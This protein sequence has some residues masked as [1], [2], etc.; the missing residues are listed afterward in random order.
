MGFYVYDRMG[1]QDRHGDDADIDSVIAEL[2]E[3]LHEDPDDQE[4]TEVSVHHGDWYV[5]VHVSG[6][7]TLGNTASVKANPRKK[8]NAVPDLY[9]RLARKSQVKSLLKLMAQGNLEE[10]QKAKW[11]PKDT[12]TAS[13]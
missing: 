1:G 6:L 4:H 8:R 2:L 5:A 3:Q 13:E 9:L 7:L 12:A 11:L 10:V